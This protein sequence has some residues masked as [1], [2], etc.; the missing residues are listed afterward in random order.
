MQVA[1]A[2]VVLVHVHK[3]VALLHLAGTGRDDV[4]GTPHGVAHEVNAIVHGLG[5]LLD[6]RTHVVDAVRIVDGTVLLDGVDSAQAVLDHHDRDLVAVIHLVEMPAQT[7]GIDGPTPLG[8]IEVRVLG[9]VVEHVAA[10][11]RHVG[12]A[13][14]G[15]ALVI[16]K[17]VEIDRSLGKDLGVAGLLYDVDALL[18]PQAGRPARIGAT[19]LHVATVVIGLALH[20]LGEKHV[21]GAAAVRIDG[22]A[23]DHAGGLVGGID[24]MCRLDCQGARHKLVM[25]RLIAALLIVPLH[26]LG[27]VERRVVLGRQDAAAH[28]VA[29]GCAQAVDLVEGDPQLDQAAEL[30]KTGAGIALKE[31]DELSARPTAVLFGQGKRQLVVAERHER[32]DTVLAALLEHTAVKVDT[33]LIGL[34]LF[35]RGKDATPVD[36]HAQTLEAHLAKKGDVFFVMMIE[37]DSFVAGIVLVLVHRRGD[38]TRRVHGAALDHVGHREALATLEVA[39]LTLVGGKC[40]APEE[41][42]GEG[43]HG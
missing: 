36:G 27:V 5:H 6:V 1:R 16:A 43:C 15:R 13:R 32:L 31:G 22:A 11:H 23:R 39:A 19:H 4:D 7:L 24:L 3:A 37:I 35:A 21:L 17:G 10:R 28:H 18:A 38:H 9:I 33:G 30:L 40:A 12:I 25:E 29:K 26:R 2:I 8:N 20:L 41:V 34:G 42:P 14:D